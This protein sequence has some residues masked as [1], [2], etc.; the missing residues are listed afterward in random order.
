LASSGKIDQALQ[1]AQTIPDE[2]SKGGVLSD[3]AY[4]LASSGIL[5]TYGFRRAEL[6][7]FTLICI[8][9]RKITVF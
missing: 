5:A 2:S 3:I 1:V 8:I 4:Q 6:C 9:K 7:Y